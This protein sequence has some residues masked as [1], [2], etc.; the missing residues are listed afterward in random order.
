L[1]HLASIVLPHTL[2]RLLWQRLIDDDLAAGDDLYI[3]SNGNL[4]EERPEGDPLDILDE[5][6]LS[7]DS[8]F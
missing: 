1:F 7:G 5:L 8:A 2:S 6:G 3:E 4:D